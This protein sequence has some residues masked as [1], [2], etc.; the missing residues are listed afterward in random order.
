MIQIRFRFHSTQVMSIDPK[1]AL[2][3]LLRWSR[4]MWRT[5]IRFPAPVR[6]AAAAS[7]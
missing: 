6:H 7:I 4:P 3:T 2:Q 1:A 5:R